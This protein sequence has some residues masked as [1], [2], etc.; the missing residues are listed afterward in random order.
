[1]SLN[2]VAGSFLLGSLS[3]YLS[4]RYLVEP[5]DVR[6]EEKCSAAGAFG[7]C[8]AT[9]YKVSIVEHK[10]GLFQDTVKVNYK[11]LGIETHKYTYKVNPYVS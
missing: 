3:T 9:Y 4:V 1:M 6:F 10:R 7:G 5:I 2:K 8:D 11:G